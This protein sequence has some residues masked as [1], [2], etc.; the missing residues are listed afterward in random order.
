MLGQNCVSFPFQYVVFYDVHF[1]FTSY[2]KNEP[3]R[4]CLTCNDLT[5]VI[6][7]TNSR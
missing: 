5:F 6:K 1:V 4:T 7:N 3:T 2:S